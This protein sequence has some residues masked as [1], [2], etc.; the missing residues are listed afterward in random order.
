MFNSITIVGRLG[1]DAEIKGNEE[2]KVV[3]F[4]VAT[5]RF[6][7]E[8]KHTT[9]HNVSVYVPQLIEFASGLKKGETVLVRGMQENIEYLGKDGQK[10]FGSRI[11][12]RYGAEIYRMNKLETEKVAAAIDNDDMPF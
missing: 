10:K 11:A 12:V 1:K 4:T 8:E 9:W 5:D 6:A 2:H 7:K 3:A